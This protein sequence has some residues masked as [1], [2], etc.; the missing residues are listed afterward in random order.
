[1]RDFASPLRLYVKD[2][3]QEGKSR[4]EPSDRG[5]NKK[6]EEIWKNKEKLYI[7]NESSRN[8]ALFLYLF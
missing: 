5:K 4:P 8:T 6:Y 2:R 1:M 7:T 3:C